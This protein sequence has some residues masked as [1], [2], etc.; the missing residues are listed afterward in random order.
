MVVVTHGVA[1][2]DPDVDAD[3]VVE[4]WAGE[5]FRGLAGV[6]GWVRSRVYKCIDNLRVGTGVGKGPE[7]QSVPRYLAVHGA[8]PFF[9]SFS[10]VVVL[11][12]PV[13]IEMLSSAVAD[14]AAFQAV[15]QKG[16]LGVKVVEDRK[17]E[18]YRAFPGIAQGNVTTT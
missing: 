12:N 5:A 1:V 13:V 8:G 9:S 14:S 17:W 3:K 4:G 11:S 7:A 10:F 2:S 16:D 18:L 15:I 6:E